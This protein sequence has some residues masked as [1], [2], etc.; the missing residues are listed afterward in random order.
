[1]LA[2]GRFLNQFLTLPC[3]DR[4]NIY[5]ADII[6]FYLKEVKKILKTLDM[7]FS[8]NIGILSIKPGQIIGVICREVMEDR[9]Q[10]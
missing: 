5:D 9:R 7:F 4:E 3:N 8:S 1:M 6:I 2:A 10:I